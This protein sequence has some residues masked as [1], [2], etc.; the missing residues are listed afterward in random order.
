VSS[1]RELSLR[2]SSNITGTDLT[3]SICACDLVSCAPVRITGRFKELII[4]AGGEN[5]AP[6]PIED[7][8]K[9]LCPAISNVMMVGDKRKYNT[10]VVTL[11]AEGATGELGPRLR[12]DSLE[13]SYRRRISSCGWLPTQVRSRERTS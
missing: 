7:N 8:I 13:A 5:V 3:S 10:C 4:G 6:V 11:K 1:P 9:L 12:H 2:D